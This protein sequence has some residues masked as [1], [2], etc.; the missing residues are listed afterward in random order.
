MFYQSLMAGWSRGFTLTMRAAAEPPVSAGTDAGRAEADRATATRGDLIAALRFPL[1]PGW[2]LP[3][4]RRPPVPE[5]PL[6]PLPRGC[7]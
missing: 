6:R 7:G 3:R 1:A 4:V 2:I 5:A